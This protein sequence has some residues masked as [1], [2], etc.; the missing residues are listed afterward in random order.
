[1]ND[2]AIRLASESRI[3]AYTVSS[4]AEQE[5]LLAEAVQDI[6]RQ[7][8]RQ[9]LDPVAKD[10][11]QQAVNIEERAQALRDPEMTKATLAA[12]QTDLVGKDLAAY[13]EV[14]V[15]HSQG[16]NSVDGGEM[17]WIETGTYHADFDRMVFEKAP[18]GS[19]SPVFVIDNN[20][21]LLFVVER[22]EAH[23]RS[24]AE[25]VGE[26]ES[27]LRVDQGVAV[28]KAAVTMLRNKASIRDLTSIEKLFNQ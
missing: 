12:L 17:G 18:V 9:E 28:R 23:S 2:E 26:I 22:L 11:A 16:P 7:A 5:R 25:V 21:Y 14:A 8:T 6:A 27:S 4:S 24:F 15:K 20:A 13:K 1:M 10:L 3:E 19:V